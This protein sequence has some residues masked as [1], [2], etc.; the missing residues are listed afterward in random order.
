MDI[1]ERYPCCQAPIDGEI[2]RKIL[3]IESN[4]A[5]VSP[6]GIGKGIG[7]SGEFQIIFNDLLLLYERLKRIPSYH[8]AK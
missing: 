1:V 8:N 6:G 5:L 7:V 2:R 4:A 3:W